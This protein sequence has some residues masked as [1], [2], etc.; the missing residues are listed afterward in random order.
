MLGAGEAQAAAGPL[1][2]ALVMRQR[3]REHGGWK[4]EEKLRSSDAFGARGADARAENNALNC[5]RRPRLR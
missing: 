4:P 2:H 5:V 1:G 3:R